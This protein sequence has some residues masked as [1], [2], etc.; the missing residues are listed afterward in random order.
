MVCVYG[1]LTVEFEGA[2]VGS[3]LITY[4]VGIKCLI[5]NCQCKFAG[6]ARVL[7]HEKAILTGDRIRLETNILDDHALAHFAPAVAAGRGV[8]TAFLLRF[9]RARL[10]GVPSAGSTT[11]KLVTNFFIP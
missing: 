7:S 1:Q 9:R 4:A 8:G 10:G 6:L 11:I 5:H 2:N 3:V